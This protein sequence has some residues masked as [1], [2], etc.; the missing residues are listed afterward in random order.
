MASIVSDIMGILQTAGVGTIGATAGWRINGFAESDGASIP[1]TLIT[2]YPT[3]GVAPNPRWRLDRPSI[4]ARIRGTIGGFD[5]PYAKAEAVRD[6]LLG[7]DRLTV[8]VGVL[9]SVTMLSD[10]IGLGPDSN[11]R[12]I[13]VVN[14]NLI[15]EPNTG[16]YRDPL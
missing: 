11:N 6:A 2:I 15:V 4:Q 16:T 9:V 7:I 3:G 14:F 10:I 1:D 5:T 13:F 12:P 8:V